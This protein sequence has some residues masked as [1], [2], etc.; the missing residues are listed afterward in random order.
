MNTPRYPSAAR[1]RATA[2]L[3]IAAFSLAPIF[4]AEAP[5]RNNP[6]L[7]SQLAAKADVNA[8]D[9]HGNTLLHLA[10]LRDDAKAVDALLEKGADAKALNDAG[11][12]PLHYGTGSET[13]V[14]ALLKHG[15]P[16][17]AVSKVGVTPLLGV[18]ARPD[19]F[20]VA[21][22]LVAAGANVNRCRVLPIGIYGGANVLAM[23]I[24]G[25]D[26]RTIALLLDAGAELNPPDGISPLCAAAFAGDLET[27]KLLLDRGANVNL[28]SSMAGSALNMALISGQ[29]AAAHLLIERGADPTIKSLRGSSTTAMIFSAYDDHCDP[30]LARL[31]IER[32]A[33]VNVANDYG[34]TALSYALKRG[35]DTPLVRLLR[36]AGAKT[37]PLIRAERKKEIPAREVPTDSDTRAALIR[38]RT[39]RSIEL[40][41]RNSTAFLE[42]GF[43]RETARCVS[44]HQQ[45]L[46]AVAFGLARE[47]GL[48]VDEQ[49]LGL[50]LHASLAQRVP[51]AELAREMDG[52]PTPAADVTLGFELDGLSAL[53]YAP[54]ETT[55][56]F[57]RYLLGVQ[58]PDGSWVAP[59]RRP[60]LEDGVITGTAWSVRALQTYPPAGRERE[61]EAAVRR[62]RAWLTAQEPALPNERV[63]QLLGLAWSG[64]TPE[65]LRPFVERLLQAQRPDG[66]WSQLPAWPSDAWATGSVLVALH[67]A[68]LPTSHAAYQR[69]LDFLLRTQFDDGSWWVRS[70]TWPFQ[71]HFDGQFPHGKDQW[72]SAAGTAW[73]AIALLSTIEPEIAP[74]RLPNA[75]QLIANFSSTVRGSVASAEAS[76]K[77]ERPDQ[78]ASV[79]GSVHKAPFPAQVAVASVSFARDIKPL[80]ER[81]CAGCHVGEKV[82]GGLSL[83]SRT[84]LLKGGQSGDPAIV[85]GRSTES[86]LLRYISDEIEDLEMPPL[87]R[88][89]KYPA[90]TADEIARVRAWI[91]AGAPWEESGS[92]G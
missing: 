82:R 2:G 54:D 17:D 71:P 24:S 65:H 35:D 44:C 73:A 14:A 47:R 5:P 8:R 4:A 39:Q 56:A 1:L 89:G 33:D 9:A 23:A 11:A 60:P 29:S 22:L 42:N 36:E 41:Q 55:Y 40:L 79:A 13:I 84:G 37:P 18:V 19:S 25:G 31:L 43:V 68:G 51:Q 66:G 16:A 21:R 87:S 27:I 57:T 62:A 30:S 34:E 58:K 83:A 80:I 92:G 81:S 3:T 59:I 91:D 76:A 53:H 32:G 72:I 75:Q 52:E 86:H 28:R 20:A 70:R 67:K 88:R 6:L 50:Q 15:A 48:R 12:T 61:T 7:D 74:E 26:R 63:F 10:A 85:P 90:L 49:Q 69:G 38:E 64:E 78:R 45:S 46:P 77:A